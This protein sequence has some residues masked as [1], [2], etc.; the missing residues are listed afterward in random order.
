MDFFKSVFSSQPDPPLGADDAED[1]EEEAAEGGPHGRAAAAVSDPGSPGGAEEEARGGGGGA[2]WGAFSGMIKTLATRSESVIQTYRRDLEEFGSGLRKETAAIR[3]AIRELPTSLEVGASV[4]QESLESVG[5]AIDDLGGSVWRGTAEII[6][7]GKDALLTMDSDGS[8]DP[9]SSP[10][11]ASAQSGGG[12]G[13]AG[14][15]YSRF[16]ARVQGIQSDPATFSEE[17]EDA[18]DFSAWIAAFQL[19]EREAEI[20]SLLA[21]NRALEGNLARLVPQVVDH[22]TFWSRYF[23]KVHKLRQA[24]DMRANLVK[25]VI[26]REEEE[27][28]LSWEVD[29]EDIHE[30]DSKEEVKQE[31]EQNVAEEQAAER[32]AE[33]DASVTKKKE[34]VETKPETVL[35]EKSDKKSQHENAAEIAPAS[36]SSGANVASENMQETSESSVREAAVEVDDKM[37]PEGKG[38][39]VE[40]CKDS[41]VS[42]VSSHPSMPEEDDLGWDEIEDLGDND[43]KK[44]GVSTGSP[45]KIDLRK[46]LSAA[47]EDEDL[48]W[49]IEDDDPIKP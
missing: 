19:A 10:S 15:P 47:E 4:A 26:S 27:E 18:E 12:G 17:P 48:S 25:R 32:G 40:S 41:D 38:E 42:V 36:V 9:A 39:P 11:G 45:N 30:K 35:E 22:D 28:D 43:E 7:Q 24:E 16:E 46:R 33:S 29:D 20:E 44:A 5:Q 2:P 8:G 3:E 6:A 34:L 14:R 1:P 13:A 37:P 49:D 23:Y 21:E 31:Q